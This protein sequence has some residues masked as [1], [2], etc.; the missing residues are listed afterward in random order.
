MLDELFAAF[1]GDATSIVAQGVEVKVT[2][3]QG[4]TISKV[5]QR[6]VP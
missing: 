5:R 1:M 6:A 4:T 3:A 2:P